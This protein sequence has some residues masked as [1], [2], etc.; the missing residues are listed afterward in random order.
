MIMLGN[1][2]GGGLE[3]CG[4]ALVAMGVGSR[5]MWSWCVLGIRQKQL[6]EEE[7]MGEGGGQRRTRHK[8]SKVKGDTLNIVEKRLKIAHMCCLWPL[9]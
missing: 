7:K 3:W 9:P 1:T 8:R 4:E 5:M 6:R 2:I